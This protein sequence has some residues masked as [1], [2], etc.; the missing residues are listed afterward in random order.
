MNYKET[1]NVMN[2]TN[3]RIY[4][5]RPFKVEKEPAEEHESTPSVG[6]EERQ[7][8][9]EPTPEEL[10]EKADVA[11]EDISISDMIRMGEESNL[12]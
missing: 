10:Q 12:K 8:E 5:I 1:L 2:D 6:D 9:G 11:R 3:E 7:D 4:G